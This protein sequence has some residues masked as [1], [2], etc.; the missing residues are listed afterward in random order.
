MENFYRGQRI[1]LGVLVEGNSPVGGAWNFDKENRL[2]PPKNYT[3][4]PYRE[5]APDEID[6]SV[7]KQLG[8]DVPSTWATTR[9]GSLKALENFID[10]HF[11]EFGP[12][13]DAM[14][15]DNW[16]LHHSLLS[17][18][19]NNGLLHPSEVI[20]AAVAEV[21]RLPRNKRV[22]A[23][24]SRRELLAH[25]ESGQSDIAACRHCTAA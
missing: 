12:Y 9:A 5:F 4:P 24:V 20:E 14:P 1:R 19:I 22:G 17:P 7:A 21:D 13:E 11:A 6:Q 16:A 10:N 3:W 8:I 25:F 2:P 15:S 18:Y 23:I